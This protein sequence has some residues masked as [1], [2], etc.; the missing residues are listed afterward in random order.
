MTQTQILT[1]Y[2]FDEYAKLTYLQLS[3]F[4][5]STNQTVIDEMIGFDTDSPNIDTNYFLI[6]SKRQT[7][8]TFPAIGNI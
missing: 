8:E 7:L 6:S 2:G 1:V 4:T 5:T 3:R